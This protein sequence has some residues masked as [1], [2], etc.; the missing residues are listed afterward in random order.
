M[1]FPDMVFSEIE[2]NIYPAED[3]YRLAMERNAVLVNNTH[4]VM[5]NN[6]VNLAVL[7]AGGF[8]SEGITTLL[9]KQEISYMVVTP[10]FD[11]SA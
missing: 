10:A 5:K 11:L 1:A 3:Y 6:N 9:K 7:V 8:H 4:K 2:K